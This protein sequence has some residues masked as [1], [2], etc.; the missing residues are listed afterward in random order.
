M[1]IA[2]F[3]PFQWWRTV[4]NHSLNHIQIWAIVQRWFSHST[5][6]VSTIIWPTWYRL[7]FHHWCAPQ[8]KVHNESFHGNIPWAKHRC[9]TRCSAQRQGCRVVAR[10]TYTDSDY[11]TTS[12]QTLYKQFRQNVCLELPHQEKEWNWKPHFA[13]SS[14][15]SYLTSAAYQYIP[16]FRVHS[17]SYQLLVPLLPPPLPILHLLTFFVKNTTA[18]TSWKEKVTHSNTT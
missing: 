17:K 11:S 14:I 9:W 8:S 5:A 7:W 4:V 10:A 2:F 1:F 18:N 12:W 15:H 6:C 3:M 13:K 16:I